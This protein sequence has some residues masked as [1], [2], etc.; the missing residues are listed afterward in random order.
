M[1][2]YFYATAFLQLLIS[3]F[4][5]VPRATLFRSRSLKAAM[6][7]TGA[8]CASTNPS[9]KGRWRKG[10]A[11]ARVETVSVLYCPQAEKHEQRTKARAQR[12]HDYEARIER[13]QKRL[14]KQTENKEMVKADRADDTQQRQQIL[15]SKACKLS[16]I[17]ECIEVKQV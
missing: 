17:W 7:K 9:Q 13:E 6:T 8:D 4:F 12:L 11:C 1:I 5:C 10:A 3:T 2:T 14:S 16:N 15:K